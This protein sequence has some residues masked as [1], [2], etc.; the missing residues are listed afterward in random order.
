MLMFRYVLLSLFYLA[1]D[2]TAFNA[3]AGE[4]E[5]QVHISQVSQYSV[6]L[7]C[8]LL[9]LLPIIWSYRLI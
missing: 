6:Y 3:L 4:W 9:Y 8:L 5:L 1:G 2:L 7:Q